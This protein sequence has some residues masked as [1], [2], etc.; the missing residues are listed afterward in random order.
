MRKYNYRYNV[1]NASNG[2]TFNFK[3]TP[4]AFALWLS[5][6]ELGGARISTM[7]GPK[8]QR[9]NCERMFVGMSLFRSVK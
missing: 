4:E 2:L 9:F 3:G 8:L 6:L 1:T 5:Q 7:W